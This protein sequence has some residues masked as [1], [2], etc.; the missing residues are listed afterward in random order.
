MRRYVLDTNIYIRA[1]RDELWSRQMESFVVGFAP[2]LF[3]HSVVALELLAGATSA[4]LEAKT[5]RAFIDPLKR[6]RR[7]ITPGHAA[8]ERAG[9]TVA[10]LVRRKL[11]SPGGPSRSFLNDCLIAASAR[12]HGFVLVTLNERD[13]S[14]IVEVEPFEFTAPWPAP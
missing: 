14:R 1:T 9:S 7:I 10:T 11:L 12:E 2:N 4:A 3:L 8:F 13:C 5:R 6:R